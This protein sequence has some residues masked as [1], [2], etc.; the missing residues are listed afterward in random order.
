MST[1]VDKAYIESRVADVT[2]ERGK[3]TI[4]HCYITMRNG[5]TV[6]G[7]S[8]CVNSSNYDEALGRKYAYE[9]AFAEL[10]PLEGYLL[11][12]RLHNK[13]R[14]DTNHDIG[15]AVQQ[16]K[17]GKA[18][19]RRGWNGKGLFAY[20]VPPGT[21]PAVAAASKTFIGSEVSYNGYFALYSTAKDI[22]NTW[23]PSG[24]DTMA[25]DWEVWA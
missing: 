22:V 13:E 15:W 23:A 7:Q 10:W 25:Q 9:D 11:A 6:T 20:F 17:N 21:Y 12:E 19:Y 4:T 5:F 3:G 2:Y 1:S 8:A 18:V 14:G 24:P 16:M